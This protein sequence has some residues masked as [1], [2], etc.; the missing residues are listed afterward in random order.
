MRKVNLFGIPVH[1]VKDEAEF[2]KENPTGIH[3]VLCVRVA[4]QPISSPSP[5]VRARSFKTRCTQCRELIWHDPL[6][7]VY[8]VG[9]VLVCL[10]CF[11]T[12][13]EEQRSAL[14]K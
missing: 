1:V 4:D 7:T 14:Y 3:V 9:S 12:M 10:T 5:R 6:S 13:S 11:T 8:P 2:L